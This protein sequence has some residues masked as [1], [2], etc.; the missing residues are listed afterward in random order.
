MLIGQKLGLS[1]HGLFG[2][3]GPTC[4][5]RQRRGLGGRVLALLGAWHAATPV[6]ALPVAELNRYQTVKGLLVLGPGGRGLPLRGGA[7]RGRA[8]TPRPSC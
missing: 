2:Q 1:F 4:D 8:L 3:C 6:P 7:A 5:H